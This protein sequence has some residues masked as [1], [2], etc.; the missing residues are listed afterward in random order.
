MNPQLPLAAAQ[1]LGAIQATSMAQT[2]SA[3]TMLGIAASVA[4]ILGV[5]GIYGVV[6]YLAAHRTREIGIRMALGAQVRDVRAMFLRHGL[7]LA[8]GGIALG[9]VVALVLTRV[10][11][12]LLFG[13]GTTD[14]VTYMQY[15]WSWARSRCWPRTC[16]RGGLA[17]RSGDCIARRR[18]NGMPRGY[19]FLSASVGCTANLRRSRR[20]IQQPDNAVWR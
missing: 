7:W 8:G 17:C 1:T 6:A 5:V 14:P 10:L 11:S 18:V 4:L 9:I 12:A 3:T 20:S 2:T 16:Q 15:P 19:S 13:V